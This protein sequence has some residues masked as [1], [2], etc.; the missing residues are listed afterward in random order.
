MAN[1]ATKPVKTVPSK[2]KATVA[3]KEFKTFKEVREALGKKHK[4][5]YNAIFSIFSRTRYDEEKG[6]KSTN[7][8]KVQY[9]DQS[10]QQMIQGTL[11]MVINK[12]N[13]HGKVIIMA[14]GLDN[15]TRAM[16]LLGVLKRMKERGEGDIEF[17]DVNVKMEIG[18]A[19]L[20]PVILVAHSDIV[21][22]PFRRD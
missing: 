3:S 10:T 12:L 4:V 17:G 2:K 22:K 14:R 13:A 16:W 1:K 8:P 21:F 15:V 9:F 20:E 5:D 19:E 7:I 6:I 11:P 18:F